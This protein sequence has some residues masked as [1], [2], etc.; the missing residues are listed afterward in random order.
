MAAAD[1]DPLVGRELSGFRIERRIGE[2][3]TGVVYRASH[4]EEPRPLAVKVLHDRFG[5]LGALERRF[6]RE[7]RVLSR[8]RHPAVVDVL[9]F[10]NTAHATFIVMELLEGETLEQLLA[11]GPIEPARALDVMRQVLEGLASA[12]RVEIV[13]RDLKPA[14]V[15]LLAGAAHVKVLDFGLAKF[16]SDQEQSLDGTLTRRGRI[17]GTP[18]YMAPEQITGTGL[19][20]RADVYAAGVVLYEMLADRRPFP[21]LRRSALLKSHLFEPVPPLSEARPGLH[22]LPPLEELVLR[23]LSKR[24]EQRYPDAGA[25]LEALA[26]LPPDAATLTTEARTRRTARKAAVAGV[27]S[28]EELLRASRGGRAA[29]MD[30]NTPRIDRRPAP[31][32]DRLDPWD[33]GG[34]FLTGLVLAVLTWWIVRQL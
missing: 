4:P 33:L 26:A 34:W 15:F 25:M 7:A 12:H 28:V 11:R 13:H 1:P 24:P 3:A 30:E 16:L 32:R 29:P 10:G 2:G 14:N 18:A 17:V 31:P 22:V 20:V 21:A 27:I 8:L 9:R 23:A 19:D 6:E 5:E